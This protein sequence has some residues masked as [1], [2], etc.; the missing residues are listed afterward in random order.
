MVKFLEPEQIVKNL[1]VVAGMSIADF[2]SGNGYFTIP[3]A[4]L[5]GDS[6][7]VF[8]LDVQRDV[9]EVVRNRAKTENLLNIEIVWS[10]LE[11]LGGSKLPDVSQDMVIISNILFQAEDRPIIFKEA[12]RVLKPGGALAVFEWDQ[13]PPPPGPPQNLRIIKTTAQEY[14]RAEKFH[15]IQELEAGSHHYGLMFKKY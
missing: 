8:A 12:M 3:L 5:V 10:N 11:V 9:L 7:K 13:T 1:G 2:G 14:A 4:K 15:F 6:G